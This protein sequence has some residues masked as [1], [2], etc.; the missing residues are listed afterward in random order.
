MCAKM[1]TK[2]YLFFQFEWWNKK[3]SLLKSIVF[4][5]IHHQNSILYTGKKRLVLIL[6]QEAK[7]MWSHQVDGMFTEH[8]RC[9]W[10]FVKYKN[11][12]K[13]SQD[14]TVNTKMNWGKGKKTSLRYLINK[15]IGHSSIA[16]KVSQMSVKRDQKSWQNI[17]IHKPK[18]FVIF[19]YFLKAC[20]MNSAINSELISTNVSAH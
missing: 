17:Q 4:Y 11:E 9:K 1:Y 6:I 20:K 8:A 2:C 18:G 19:F 5:F 15:F 10:H 14:P 12:K 3:Q 7:K 16:W 13:R